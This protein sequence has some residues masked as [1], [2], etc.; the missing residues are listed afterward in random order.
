MFRK[1]IFII[2]ASIILL[3]P[4]QSK[5]TS[6]SFFYG[7]TC[8]H[9]HTVLKYFSENQIAERYNIILREVWADRNNASIFIKDME[10]AGQSLGDNLSVPI[11][12]LDGKVLSGD[13]PI[14]SFFEQEHKLG[15]W[16]QI[17][18]DQTQP[19]SAQN[20][21]VAKHTHTFWGFFPKLSLA[22]LA[23]AANPCAF[24]VLI[25]LLISIMAAG[26]RRRILGA[27]FAF[28]LA[29]FISYLAM[30]FG[31][32]STF[33]TFE[34]TKTITNIAG[35]LALI[36]GLFN[37]KDAIW[38]GKGGFKMEV[39]MAWRGRMRI[40]LAKI[41]SIPGA[42]IVGLLISLFLLPC[43]S[44]PYI[45]ILGLLSTEATVTCA[46]QCLVAYNIIFVLPMIIVTLAIYFGLDLK[47]AEQI[48]TKNLRTL[49]FIIG[50]LLIAIAAWTFLG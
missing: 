24:A 10:A 3:S 20:I 34:S 45:V 11:L 9:C 50:L 25:I 6:G 37:L 17:S 27:G 14:I 16:P 40:V 35:A 46:T 5:A 18:S 7:E 15:N 22:A 44:G 41:T 12:I 47:K 32:Y 8:P 28:A 4:L 19:S 49:H 43:T 29:V 33:A 39:P 36:L 23:S 1:T 38:Y 30:G 21:Q 31:L 42:F 13:K 48:R 2:L 26:N